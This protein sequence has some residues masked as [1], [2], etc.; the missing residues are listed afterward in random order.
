MIDKSQITMS[1]LLTSNWCSADNLQCND[2]IP[3]STQTLYQSDFNNYYLLISTLDKKYL[4]QLIYLGLSLSLI[5]TELT[6][7]RAHRNTTV[8]CSCS[9]SLLGRHHFELQNMCKTWEN[10]PLKS[11]VIMHHHFHRKLKY[12]LR[13]KDPFC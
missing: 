5:I 2:N 6:T 9:I 11:T 1:H 4:E 7:S 12:H 3:S 8:I 13:C 10:F